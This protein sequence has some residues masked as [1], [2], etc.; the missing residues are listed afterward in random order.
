MLKLGG[1]LSRTMEI[2]YHWLKRQ[3][4]NSKDIFKVFQG[5]LLYQGQV[6]D[7]KDLRIIWAFFFHLS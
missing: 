7:N 2:Y 5:R 4:G 1:F 6:C 3:T